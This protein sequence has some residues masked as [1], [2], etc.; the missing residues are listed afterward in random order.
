MGASS[1]RTKTTRTETKPRWWVEVESRL[2][3]VTPEDLPAVP[4]ALMSSTPEQSSNG[5][6]GPYLTIHDNEVFLGSLKRDV[7]EGPDGPR[8]MV[9]MNDLRAL[10]AAIGRKKERHESPA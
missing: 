6:G 4:W 3:L 5:L 9:V 1:P 10:R 8:G 2:A 7:N